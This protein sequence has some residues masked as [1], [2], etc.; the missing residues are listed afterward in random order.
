MSHTPGPWTFRRNFARTG[1]YE[2]YSGE[3]PI[4]IV[5]NRADGVHDEEIAILIAAAPDLLEA[6][7]ALV[8]GLF[9][10]PDQSD[11]AM[12]V[13]NASAAIAKATGG[14]V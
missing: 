9:D 5:L 11:A 2:I 14:E 1:E 12:L 3:Q 7:Q 6:L 8:R 13:T 4:A 10:G